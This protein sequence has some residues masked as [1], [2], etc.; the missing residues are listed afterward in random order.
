MISHCNIEKKEYKKIDKDIKDLWDVVKR[1]NICRIGI[2]RRKRE[3]MEQ[4]Q[5][6]EEII[7]RT[8]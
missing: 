4:K 8:L 1:S 3:R 5:I 2:C 7:L 6:F